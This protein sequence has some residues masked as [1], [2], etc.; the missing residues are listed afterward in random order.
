MTHVVLLR[1]INVGGHRSFPAVDSPRTT[2]TPR[3]FQYRRSGNVRG[4][5]GHS[6]I[7]PSRRIDSPAPVRDGDRHLPG[8]RVHPI[9][10]GGPFRRSAGGGGHGPV[11]EH[12]VPTPS[13][14]APRLPMA[15]P[16]K[17]RWLLRILAPGS[18]GFVFGIYRRHMKVIACLGMLD[19]LFGA[20]ATTRNW[21]TIR[22]IAQVLTDGGP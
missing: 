22:A 9:R 16:S 4:P 5:R 6:T 17:G 10:V 7:R 13:L 18:P 3:C 21:N 1:G 11:R 20:P 14:R 12:S 8:T 15:F 2:E 19:R